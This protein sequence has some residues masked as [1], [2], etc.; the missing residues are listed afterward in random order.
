ML[1]EFDEIIKNGWIVGFGCV[2]IFNFDIASVRQQDIVQYAIN[3]AL[4]SKGGW[5]ITVNAD[6]LRQSVL[7]DDVRD[8]LNEA[9]FLVA[10]G[11]PVV[12]ASRLQGTPLPER[13][14]GSD[15]AWSL[16]DAAANSGIPIFLLGGD[17]GV[18]EAAATV[19][20]KKIP[21]ILIAGTYCP[22]LG[23][24]ESERELDNIKNALLNCGHFAICFV[25]LSFP[26]QDYLIRRLKSDFEGVWFI[27]VGISL[28]YISGAVPRAP[29]WM[30]G[31][32]FEWAHRMVFDFRR[33]FPRYVKGGIPFVFSLLIRSA[34][35]GLARR[36]KG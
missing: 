36:R 18:A 26:K 31:I 15:L 16:S 7:S 17:E 27:G 32:G 34:L 35:Y 20:K 28:S 30:R 13:V 33:L 4:V 9:D 19:L 11:M 6:H 1:I 12:W 14:A 22:P 5:I 23:F 24:E 2:R 29:R 8:L 25:A 10:D 3:Q 21:D